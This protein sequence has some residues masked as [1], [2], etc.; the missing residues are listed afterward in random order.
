MPE[1]LELGTDGSG[2][3]VDGSGVAESGLIDGS[4]E[5]AGG[6]AVLLAEADF[7]FFLKWSP[8]GMEDRV[9]VVLSGEV[10]IVDIDINQTLKS[11]REIDKK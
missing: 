8:V 10:S 4:T 11:E 9:V 5:A 1:G 2:G 6:V 7:E 3:V